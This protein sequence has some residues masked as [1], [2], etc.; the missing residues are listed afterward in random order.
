MD[1]RKNQQEQ[2]I[3]SEHFEHKALK[4]KDARYSTFSFM[5]YDIQMA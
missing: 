5:L 4:L 1:K 3:L 2:Q